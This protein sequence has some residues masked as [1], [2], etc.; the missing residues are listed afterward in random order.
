[1][2]SINWQDVITSL[3]GNVILLAAVGWLIKAL[4]SHRFAL[5]A[6]KFKIELKASADT[7]IER[8]RAFLTRGSR[9][10]EQQ[11]ETLTKLH[12]HLLRAQGYLQLEAATIRVE[13][14]VSR[15][16]YRRVC[17]EAIASAH[18]TLLDGRLLIPPDLA[19]ECDRFFLS[20]FRGQTDLNFA[21]HP[22]VVDGLQ[23]AEFFRNA[24]ETAREEVPRIL[25]QIE[26]AARDV[27]HGETSR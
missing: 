23:R 27:I 18:E 15:E 20:V 8:V 16:E 17:A 3:G 24:Q 14:E 22:M 25:D 4:L 7:E 2:A 13:G 21:Q 26:I 1:M 9:V 6:E 12:R 11:V 10:H 5:E 19:R